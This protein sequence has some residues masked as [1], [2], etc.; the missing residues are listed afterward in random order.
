MVHAIRFH[1]AGGPEVLKWEEVDVDNPGPG[2]VKIR[3]SA[4]GLNFIDTYHRS[5]LYP[6]PDLPCI[7][8]MEG[9]GVVE[10]VKAASD[11]YAPVSGTITAVNEA[12]ADAPGDVNADPMMA[13]FFAITPKDGIDLDGF[14]DEDAYKALIG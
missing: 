14:M 9:A 1:Q 13:W 2:Q 5:G 6:V 8:G 7:P 12:L 10:S 11:V 3:Q 4:I